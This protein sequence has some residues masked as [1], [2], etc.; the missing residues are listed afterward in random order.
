MDT[1]G[2]LQMRTIH[3]SNVKCTLCGTE[4]LEGISSLCFA[5]SP[6]LLHEYLSN[7]LFYVARGRDGRVARMG[8]PGTSGSADT[9]RLSSV[10]VRSHGSR[11]AGRIHW[12]FYRCI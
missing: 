9:G 11:A 8:F 5:R 2:G 6:Q 4:C 7:A 10:A 1:S 12:R 3:N